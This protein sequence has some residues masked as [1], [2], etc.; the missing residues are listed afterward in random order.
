MIVG[1]N[2][3]IINRFKKVINMAAAVVAAFLNSHCCCFDCDSKHHYCTIT[4]I[5]MNIDR[6]YYRYLS[7]KRR[8]FMSLRLES[9]FCSE[10]SRNRSKSPQD[11]VDSDLIC[12][13]FSRQ[14]EPRSCGCY[15]R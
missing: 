1:E 11:P 13:A 6:H 4:I 7:V 8:A 14:I 2:A 9:I 15:V 12:D 5:T 10:D 3:F